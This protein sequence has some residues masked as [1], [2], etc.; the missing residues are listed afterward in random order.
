M[1]VEVD[2][3][4]IFTSPAEDF[5]DVPVTESQRLLFPIEYD[6]LLLPASLS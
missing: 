2:T 6:N 3:K 5:E 1:Q 4:T